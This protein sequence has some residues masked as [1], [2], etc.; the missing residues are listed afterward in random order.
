M[1]CTKTALRR[2]PLSYHVSVLSF[3]SQRTPSSLVCEEF[4][5]KV[6]WHIIWLHKIIHSRRC[7]VSCPS[8]WI[9]YSLTAGIC[10]KN[11]TW[12]IFF[13]LASIYCWRLVAIRVHI[14]NLTSQLHSRSASSLFI[15]HASKNRSW[16]SHHSE[17]HWV[18]F[19]FMPYSLLVPAKPFVLNVC[20]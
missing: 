2:L 15:F 16:K 7:A 1:S 3:L 6:R 14:I 17:C 11:K 5:H 18:I 19:E 13:S 4:L 10:W 20:D 8:R 9:P 12:R